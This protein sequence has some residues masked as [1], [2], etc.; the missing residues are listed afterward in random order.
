MSANRDR[1]WRR[2]KSRSKGGAFP[3]KNKWKKQKNWKLMYIR[4]EKLIRAKKLGQEY[5]PKTLRQVL[6]VEQPVNEEE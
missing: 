3:Q 5:P 1:A 2:A 4:R 6:D